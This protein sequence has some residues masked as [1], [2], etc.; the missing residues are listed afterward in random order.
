LADAMWMFLVN[1]SYV[2]RGWSG[3]SGC[4]IF[5]F[6]ISRISVIVTAVTPGCR[7][8]PSH[9]WWPH[10]ATASRTSLTTILVQSGDQRKPPFVVMFGCASGRSSWLS[11]IV[12]APSAPWRCVAPPAVPL[13]RALASGSAT[14]SVVYLSVKRI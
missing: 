5:P 4:C 6:L 13:S 7:I 10:S 1:K 9:H 11:C 2:F 14:R 8:R 12:S 3:R